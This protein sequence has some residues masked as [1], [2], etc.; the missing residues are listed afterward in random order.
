[1]A[2]LTSGHG[3][4]SLRHGE[5]VN[6]RSKLE[7]FPAAIRKPEIRSQRLVVAVWVEFLNCLLSHRTLVSFKP[8]HRNRRLVIHNFRLFHG[9]HASAFSQFV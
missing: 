3:S 9:A 1:M 6:E 2:F 4:L 7:N 5:E 8:E